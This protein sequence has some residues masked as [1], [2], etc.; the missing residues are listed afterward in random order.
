M[1]VK[2][3]HTSASKTEE[4]FKWWLWPGY[5]V[6]TNLVNWDLEMYKI[7]PTEREEIQRPIECIL[8]SHA[9][10]I[11]LNC[12]LLSHPWTCEP[13]QQLLPLALSTDLAIFSLSFPQ[14]S[15]SQSWLD[16]AVDTR[17]TPCWYPAYCWCSY[18][19][20]QVT[21]IST[22]LIRDPYSDLTTD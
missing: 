2:C 3:L 21:L 11:V 13:L 9:A 6:V 15:V 16:F 8:A 18:W 5:W 14:L 19:Q 12:V 4:S 10:H 17:E 22:H 1:A 7:I 20:S